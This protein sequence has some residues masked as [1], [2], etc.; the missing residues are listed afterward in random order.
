MRQHGVNTVVKGPPWYPDPE[1][2]DTFVSLTEK[3]FQILA[4]SGVNIIRLGTMWPGVEPVKGQY[5]MTYL[6][7]LDRI[8]Q[9][10]A[11]YG[12]VCG[13]SERVPASP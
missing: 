8:A 1:N 10:G 3:D 7:Q 2:F 4:D 12:V 9:T 11:K 5:N 13:S 6:A